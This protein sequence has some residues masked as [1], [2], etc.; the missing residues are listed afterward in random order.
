MLPAAIASWSCCWT[1]V[2]S[3]LKTL[4]KSMMPVRYCCTPSWVAAV[5]ALTLRSRSSACSRDLK[6]P[7]RG[8]WTSRP[9]VRTVFW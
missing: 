1:C 8:V 2:V 9:A 5:A 6:K 7:R 3:R 4:L